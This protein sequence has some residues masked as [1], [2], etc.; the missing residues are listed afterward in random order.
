MN[1]SRIYIKLSDGNT[2]KVRSKLSHYNKCGIGEIRHKPQFAYGMYTVDEAK[3]LIKELNR[4]IKYIEES[5]K[6]GED[7]A[8]LVNVVAEETYDI[9]A[10]SEEEAIE[11]AQCEFDANTDL[12]YDV[13]EDESDVIFNPNTED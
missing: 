12:T 4:H 7:K 5:L 9:Q 10:A 11:K 13:E 6:N 3:G 8:Y 2:T 1:N